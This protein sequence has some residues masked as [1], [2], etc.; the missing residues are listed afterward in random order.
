[1]D[2]ENQNQPLSETQNKELDRLAETLADM[3]VE[4]LTRSGAALIEVTLMRTNGVRIEIR[5]RDHY[6]AHF[7]VTS[8]RHSAAFDIK[9]C[10]MIRGN[11]EPRAVRFVKDW[12]GQ[13][14]V[15]LLNVWDQ[16]RPGTCSIGESCYGWNT[17]N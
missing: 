10:D 7:H 2:P 11:L 6:P 13:H 3:L 5:P 14:Q 12:H 17:P 15:D 1:M 16:T 9:T 8:G 4:G